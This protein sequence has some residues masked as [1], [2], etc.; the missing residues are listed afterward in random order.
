MDAA[1]E[2]HDNLNYND[3]SFPIED[4]SSRITSDNGSEQRF[5]HEL[6]TFT[7]MSIFVICIL[8]A[9][10]NGII[11]WLLG[12]RIKRNPFITYI[13]NLAVADFGLLVSWIIILFVSKPFD[14]RYK[15]PTIISALF[16]FLFLSM[17]GA[18]QF[19]LTAIS[20]DR[21]VAIF[22]P[23]WHQC[24]R[25]AHLS[26]VVCVVIWV[27]SSLLSM[28]TVSIIMIYFNGNLILFSYQFMV[29]AVLCLPLMTSATL[30]LFI[31]VCSKAQ[32]QRR[33][34]LLTIILVTLLCFLFLAFPLNV[35]VIL[36][37]YNYIHSYF[38]VCALALSC[39]NSSVNPMIYFLV[40]RQRKARQKESLKVILQKVF[41]EE[42]G[43][44]EELQ[45]PDETQL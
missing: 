35:I 31:K 15:F 40:G 4:I 18:G 13:L 5:F 21:C 28:I 12:F 33:G 20:I 19:L 26:T 43:C 10:G 44:A 34:K 25:P 16:Y 1:L 38:E 3:T 29:N 27:L 22:F 6:E 24:R 41:R 17:Y 9:V 7:I 45:T 14:K 30:A 39:L 42:E 37:Y 8:G 32:Q 36:R 2:Y 23:L 11:I